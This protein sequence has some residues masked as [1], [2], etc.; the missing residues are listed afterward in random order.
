MKC[1][2][3][4]RACATSVCKMHCL[5]H[6]NAACAPS[7]NGVGR[8][9]SRMSALLA[10]PLFHWPLQMRMTTATRLTAARA[11]FPGPR[12]MIRYGSFLLTAAK[13]SAAPASQT[14]MRPIRFR[15]CMNLKNF[16]EEA[17]R[18][19]CPYQACLSGASAHPHL[20]A[21]CIKILNSCR[22]SATQMHNGGR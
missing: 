1:R 2:P 19:N 21:N 6:S 5:R 3:R 18:G 16:C 9:H 7:I 22:R 12:S 10:T 4:L 15:I 20:H 11:T 14:R 17:G 13:T 8:H